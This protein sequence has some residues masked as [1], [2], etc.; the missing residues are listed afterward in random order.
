MGFPYHQ[1]QVAKGCSKIDLIPR[2]VH[3]DITQFL[4]VS[5]LKSGSFAGW[6]RRQQAPLRRNWRRGA[7]HENR[8]EPKGPRVAWL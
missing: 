1:R 5:W 8:E 2:D 3:R 6:E 4:Y 7:E